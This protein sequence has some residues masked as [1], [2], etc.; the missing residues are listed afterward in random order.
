M[1]LTKF[2]FNY[3][4]VTGFSD[5][6]FQSLQNFGLNIARTNLIIYTNQTRSEEFV[7]LSKFCTGGE[8]V[9][10]LASGA[11]TLKSVR[12]QIPSRAPKNLLKIN[13]LVLL[14]FTI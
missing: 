8:T 4:I 3:K 7:S 9:D 5:D 6:F 11:S 14:V 2:S 13:K 12:V 1:E 10:T